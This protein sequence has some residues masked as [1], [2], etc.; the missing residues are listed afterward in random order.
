MAR[1]LTVAEICKWEKCIFMI[2]TNECMADTSKQLLQ[3][4]QMMAFLSTVVEG[5]AESTAIQWPARI[6]VSQ[7]L[8]Y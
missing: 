6:I 8:Q 2:Q 7:T 4:R 3:H 5:L 1:K